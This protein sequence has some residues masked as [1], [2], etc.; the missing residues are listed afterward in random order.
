M[1]DDAPSSS[2]PDELHDEPDGAEEVW[3]ALFIHGPDATAKKLATH[4]SITERQVR[5]HLERLEETYGFVES[6]P[7]WSGGGRWRFVFS[8]ADDATDD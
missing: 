5:N 6:R 3:I 7:D 1:E 8:L 2:V 4:T